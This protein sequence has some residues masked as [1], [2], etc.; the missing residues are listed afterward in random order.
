MTVDTTPLT[1]GINNFINIVFTWVPLGLTIL[2]VPAAIGVGILFG[3]KII[4]MVKAAF[5]GASR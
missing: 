3:G 4:N 2:G 5:G 1:E